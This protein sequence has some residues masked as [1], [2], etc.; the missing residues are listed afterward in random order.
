MNSPWDPD[1][2]L[3]PLKLTRRRFMGMAILSASSVVLPLPKAW[4]AATGRYCTPGA[5]GG[6]PGEPWADQGPPE[7]IA[8]PPNGDWGSVDPMVGSHFSSSPRNNWIMV[9]HA[10]YANSH[11]NTNPCTSCNDPGDH[12]YDFCIDR[13]GDICNTGRWD[14]STGAHAKG[15]NSCSI[16]IML[17]GCFGG[18]SSGNVGGPSDSQLCSLAYLSLHLKTPAQRNN[19]RPHARCHHWKCGCNSC[20]ATVTACPGTNLATHNTTN[21]WTNQG[22]SAMDRMLNMRAKLVECGICEGKCPP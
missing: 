9:H 8:A 7:V 12:T 5:V 17:H 21:H 19:H 1:F 4:A 11:E 20:D 22:E 14:E 15:C 10:G 2:K 16:G 3:V 18:C 13:A 6:E